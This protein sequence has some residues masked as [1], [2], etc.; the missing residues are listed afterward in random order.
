M[1]TTP[2]GSG[3][4][5]Q[6]GFSFAQRTF[7]RI[8]SN[9]HRIYPFKELIDREYALLDGREYSPPPPAPPAGAT[10][11]PTAS[12]AQPDSPRICA[13]GITDEPCVRH[14]NRDLFGLALSG[15]GI[16]SATFNLGLLQSLERKNLLQ[17][18]QY[19]STVSGGGYVG[20]FWTA[21]RHHHPDAVSHFP[22]EKPAPAPPCADPGPRDFREP[23]PI[24][25]LREFSRFLMPRVGF[26]HSETWD[27]I[28]TILGGMLPALT[29]ALAVLVLAH[30]AW[31]AAVQWLAC[32]GTV[33]HVDCSVAFFTASTFLLLLA[34][35]I[36]WR[37]ARK[38]GATDSWVGPYMLVTLLATTIAATLWCRWIGTPLYATALD[39]WPVA[40]DGFQIK[41]AP[42]ANPA[43]SFS[44]VP[45]GPAIAWVVTALALLG[46]RALFSGFERDRDDRS[47]YLTKLERAA[48]RLFAGA[49]LWTLLAGIWSLTLW[50]SSRRDASTSA[51]VGT[52]GALAAAFGLLFVWLRDWL[53]KPVRE[54]NG[55]ALLRR[56]VTFLKPVVPQLLANLTVLLLLV[57]TALLLEQFYLATSTPW[58]PLAA[59]GVIVA[60]LLLFDPH[61]V[62]MHD[63]YRSRIARCYLGAAHA[64]EH[65]DYR[66]FTSEQPGDDIRIGKLGESPE[67]R[68]PIH[69]VC[70]TANNLAGDVLGSLYRGG[71]SAVISPFGLSLGNYTGTQPDLRFS[72]ALTASAAAFNS[73]MGSLSV[74]LGPGVAF[75]MCAFN[76]RLGL[77]RPHPLNPFL[78]NKLPG[79][80]FFFEMIGSTDCDPVSTRL[81]DALEESK[82]KFDKLPPIQQAEIAG[83]AVHLSDGGHF[84]NLA[85]YELVRR[86]CRYIIASD[87]GADPTVVFD[88]LANAQRRVREDFGIEIEID[89]A[90]LRPDDKGRS[91]QHA[92]VG[93]IHYDGYE[94]SDKG[95]LIYFK[96]SLTG[97]EPP[98]VLQY[99]ARNASFPHEST[100]D[101]FYDEPQWEAYRQ[102][103]QHA[104]N[105]VLRFTE[106]YPIGRHETGAHYVENIFLDAGRFWHPAPER[107]SEVFL[108]LTERCAVLENDIRANAPVALRAEF[109]PEAL[110][111]TPA[112]A[113]SPNPVAAAKPAQP[114]AE[115][116]S[117]TLYYLM[118]VTQIMEDVWLGAEL[119]LY[120]SHPLNDGWM[121]YFHRWASTP[122]FRRWWPVI[123]P[124]YGIGFRDFVRDRFDLTYAKDSL[125]GARLGL[126]PS[127]GQRAGLAWDYWRQRGLPVP[128]DAKILEFRLTLDAVTPG[129][130]FAPFPVGLLFYRQPEPKL[131]VWDNEDFF[132][133][134]SLN[135]SGISA[136]FL[137]D[138][139][140]QFAGL[141]LRV[142]FAGN[143]R[144]RTDPAS[145]LRRLH[146]INF[147][148][149]RG[150]EPEGPADATG[151]QSLLRKA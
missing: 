33:L 134:A 145:R 149:S 21:W 10:A 71:R 106:S 105:A 115:E 66:R 44:L 82:Y 72:A 35:E 87:C 137:T 117:Q 45:F 69:L 58:L 139:I 50:L 48:G 147:Y 128:S 36:V 5:A 80:R 37:R 116:N 52:S 121:N 79:L 118:L 68:R 9:E 111:A 92:V 150:F 60:T 49:L 114:T 65:P 42:A 40:M 142:T 56:A 64:K 107:Q 110:A 95:T 30:V 102:L 2:A 138:I 14:T 29:A 28:V 41:F 123:R 144:A 43:G 96:P 53:A 132:V 3:G 16:R 77:W 1:N 119:D 101:Q 127:D 76:L 57:L 131:A 151:R 20:G 46:A 133:P 54:T 39:R 120:W 75:L 83:K 129:V 67:K 73:Q 93:T 113:S 89:V 148:K 135:G 61:R 99:Q 103:G 51:A 55:S 12:T 126:L 15:G 94:G 130:S 6:P 26:F 74:S 7:A 22:L 104:G 97:D 17:Y 112:P 91:R 24:R 143:D 88:D 23:A 108:S 4:D 84:E 32:A 85:L 140:K 47:T 27:G 136:R 8:A 122:S 59:A 141:N 100:G 25:H 90:P 125:P 146:Q 19:L 34:C 78:G 98:D 86:H 18:L 13:P 109:F 11:A 124:I 81:A 62:G 38:R 31:L 63:F 70:T